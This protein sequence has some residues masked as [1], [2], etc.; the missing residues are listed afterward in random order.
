MLNQI[1]LITNLPRVFLANWFG[2]SDDVVSTF[3]F[4]ERLVSSSLRLLAPILLSENW[5]S[6]TQS[7]RQK[8][9]RQR[10]VNSASERPV[11]W[12]LVMKRFVNTCCHSCLYHKRLI[13]NTQIKCSF[14]VLDL[15]RTL[16]W[17]F[18][19]PVVRTL[20]VWCLFCGMQNF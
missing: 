5:S 14:L 18:R 13:I 3:S 6:K 16:S 17:L 2:T 9:S 8:E 20:F 10:K 12:W 7:T 4:Q 11:V 1:K 15:K 19:I